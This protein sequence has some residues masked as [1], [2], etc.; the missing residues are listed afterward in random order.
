M[1]IFQHPDRFVQRHIG[2]NATELQDMLKQIGLP[3]LEALIAETIP[4]NIRRA[5]PLQLPAALSESDYLA[6]LKEIAAKNKLYKSYI[7]QGLLSYADAQ[8]HFA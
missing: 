4:E 7:G 2:P 8:C 3:S 6:E 5:T 1:S